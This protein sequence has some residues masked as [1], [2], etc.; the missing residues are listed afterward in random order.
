VS[1]AGKHAVVTGGARGIGRAAA[2][3]L[4]RRGA[5]VSVVSRSAGI[6][7]DVTDEAQVQKAFQECREA[8]GPIAILVNNAGIAESAAVTRTDRAMWERII[9][10][11]LTGT[12]LCTREALPD[13]IAAG[14]GRIVNVASIAGLEGAP[15]ISAYSASKH[16]VVGF[17]KAVAAEYAG[18]GITVN[19]VC[20]GYTDTEMLGRTLANIL[21][22]TGRN[23]AETRE[24]LARG[25]PG[26][27]I[28]TADEVAEAIVTLVA[29]T[30]TGRT[31]VI[32]LPVSP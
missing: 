2:E 26:G 8:N 29:G 6:R 4:E 18:K 25:N 24:L 28:A 20:P 7:A 12:F 14:W 32:P 31:V 3:L 16:G 21:A 22:R 19:A 13:M 17:T 9:A 27:R 23:E 5:R 30:A 1:L 10:I 11:N 15:Y